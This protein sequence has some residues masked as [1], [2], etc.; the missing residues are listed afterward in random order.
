MKKEDITGLSV[1]QLEDRVK[2]E[3]ARLHR[4][5]FAHATSPLENPSQIRIARKEVARLLTAITAKQQAA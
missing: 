1:G 5:R 2:E 3:R 4:L